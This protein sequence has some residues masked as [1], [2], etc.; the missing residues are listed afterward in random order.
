MAKVVLVK[1]VR[2]S[3]CESNE[4]AVVVGNTNPLLCGFLVTKREKG[5]AGAASL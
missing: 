2:L 5:R 4:V 3:S 1:S